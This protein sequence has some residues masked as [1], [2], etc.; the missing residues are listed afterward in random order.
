MAGDKDAVD[1]PDLLELM[2]KTPS[3]ADAKAEVLKAFKA[4][5]V[6]G[7]GTMSQGPSNPPS[8]FWSYIFFVLL[9]MC[10]LL[11]MLLSLLQPSSE[12]L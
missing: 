8:C 12:A 2:A 11:L 3:K 9:L 10:D 7:S 6:A 1:F 4:H 5:D